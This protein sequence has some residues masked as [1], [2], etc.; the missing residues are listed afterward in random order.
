MCERLDSRSFARSLS[1][2]DN[3]MVNHRHGH[4]LSDY[5]HY[6]RQTFYDYNQTC[7]MVDGSASIHPHNLGL[8]MLHGISSNGPHGHAKQCVIN[9]FDTDYLL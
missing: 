5:V 3:L 1:L 2:L 4:S 9:A 7:Q 8:L 6:M